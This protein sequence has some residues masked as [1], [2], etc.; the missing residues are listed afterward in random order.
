MTILSECCQKGLN[1]RNRI[2][3][4][5]GGFL[6]TFHRV[7]SC[8]KIVKCHKTFHVHNITFGKKTFGH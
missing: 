1:I 8:V 2:T 3:T 6:T 7:T 4:T 5:F